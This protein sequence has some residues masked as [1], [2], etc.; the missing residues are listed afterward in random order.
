MCMRPL[1]SWR[2][3]ASRSPFRSS[4]SPNLD[5]NPDP[6]PGPTPNANPNQVFLS[7]GGWNYNCFPAL[8]MVSQ[9]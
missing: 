4:P 2:P 9:P 3:E 1:P 5:P 7:M 6:N 8:Y